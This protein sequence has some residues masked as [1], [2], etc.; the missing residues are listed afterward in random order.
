VIVLN[1]ALQSERGDVEL[2]GW[3]GMFRRHW[4]YWLIDLVFPTRCPRAN[5]RA[6]KV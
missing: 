4:G 2:M 1:I 5:G 6:A 3:S